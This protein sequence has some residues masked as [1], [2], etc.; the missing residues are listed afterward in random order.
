MR[1]P[2]DAV[3]TCAPDRK[4]LWAGFSDGRTWDWTKLRAS[5]AR[6]LGTTQMA[7]N[8]GRGSLRWWR[9]PSRYDSL[10]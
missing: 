4:R 2:A 10:W 9:W 7:W 8:W 3:R 1:P 5:R 6:R